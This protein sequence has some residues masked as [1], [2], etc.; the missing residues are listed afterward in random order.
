MNHWPFLSTL[1]LHIWGKRPRTPEHNLGTPTARKA[2][3]S[4]GR[5][6]KEL[7]APLP[8]IPRGPSAP[9]LHQNCRKTRGIWPLIC[10]GNI[11]QIE[12]AKMA[13]A[14]PAGLSCGCVRT[15]CCSL[16]PKTL[17]VFVRH[18]TLADRHKV[19]QWTGKLPAGFDRRSVKRGG[20]K[21][22]G[23]PCGAPRCQFASYRNS[24]SGKRRS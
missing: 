9:A 6:M 2:G 12:L 23:A 5:G 7:L 18:R 24:R 19:Y 22:K 15:V 20:Y 21:Q 11:T 17:R 1:P 13:T 14:L 4:L 8:G 16:M 3:K 10:Q